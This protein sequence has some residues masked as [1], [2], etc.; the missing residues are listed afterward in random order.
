MNKKELRRVMRLERD[1]FWLDEEKRKQEEQK[2]FERLIPYLRPEMGLL[3][4]ASFGSEFNTFHIMEWAMTHGMKV[5]LPRLH[6]RT[7]DFY[8]VRDLE[9]LKRHSYGMLEPEEG[10]VPYTPTKY[11]LL[12]VPGLAFDLKGGRLGYGGGYYDKFLQ[13]HP[14]P[15]TL[16]L[17]YLCQLIDEVPVDKTDVR[18]KAVAIAEEPK[19]E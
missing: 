17:S 2:V 18:L 16:G 9:H 4:Y 3:S 5:Y 6:D 19:K 1:S 12:L 7:M 15:M 14:E 10:G 8:E 13:E 11:D